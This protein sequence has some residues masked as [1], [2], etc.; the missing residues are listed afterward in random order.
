M[1]HTDAF[2]K[3]N[4]NKMSKTDY[5]KNTQLTNI[6][7]QFLEYLY[8]NILFAPF[9]FLENSV[10]ENATGSLSRTDV[11]DTSAVND[12]SESES[13]VSFARH[14]STENSHDERFKME[15]YR[16]LTNRAFTPFTIAVDDIIPPF[17]PYLYRGTL[18]NWDDVELSRTFSEAPYIEVREKSPFSEFP[19][20]MHGLTIGGVGGVYLRTQVGPSSPPSEDRKSFDEI[21]TLKVTKAG[22]LFRKDDL[23]EGGKRSTNR[24]WKEWSV[25]LTGSQLLFF[26]DPSLAPS[27]L[28]QATAGE[29]R[30]LLSP[31]M[32]LRPEEIVSLKDCVAVYDM[33]YT[34]HCNTF[35]FVM[36]NG[37][38]L[39]LRTQEEHTMNEWI[40][41][42]NYASAFR[43]TGLKLRTLESLHVRSLPLK[44]TAEETVLVS[45]LSGSVAADG[46]SLPQDPQDTH[47]ITESKSGEHG[48]LDSNHS[49]QFVLSSK[50]RNLTGKITAVES[51]LESNLRVC[52]QYSLAFPFQKTTRDRVQSLLPS[53]SKK[54]Q[55]LR[56]ELAKLRCYQLVLDH[57]LTRCE[58]SQERR[59]MASHTSQATDMLKDSTTEAAQIPTSSSSAL[60]VKEVESIRPSSD[61]GDHGSHPVSPVTSRAASPKPKHHASS[62]ISSLSSVFSPSNVAG[63]GSLL[64]PQQ[65]QAEINDAP[66]ALPPMLEE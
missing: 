64:F 18:D 41:L 52:R 54:I 29:D 4:K 35:R 57:D 20:P 38:H 34:K 12:S 60:D 40:H 30:C 22:L 17:D 44:T 15:G 65:S 61:F 31:H 10:D 50:L 49:R 45:A 9:V 11:T 13:R 23:I 48:T 56:L 25:I 8:D 63:W 53:L 33:S 36:S 21:W 66:H 19:I 39:L 6:S 3:S 1:L 24:K 55:S 7:P 51:E 14:R 47:F 16:F 5:I 58:G 46:D 42:I 62:S 59:S 28:A 27:L 43:S 37:R 32:F 26:R 2:N